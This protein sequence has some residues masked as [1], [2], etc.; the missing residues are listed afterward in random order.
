MWLGSS[1]AERLFFPY[2]TPYS[3]YTCSS[4]PT[5]SPVPLYFVPSLYFLTCHSRLTKPVPHTGKQHD[6][7]QWGQN[8]AHHRS[9]SLPG[10]PRTG[11]VRRD[12]IQLTMEATHSLESQGQALSAGSKS[13]SPWKP[14]TDWRAKDRHHQQG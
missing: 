2:S 10:E 4:P 12:E 14:L 5:P 8:T 1:P 9:H 6:S 13:S 7:H 3:L 11:I